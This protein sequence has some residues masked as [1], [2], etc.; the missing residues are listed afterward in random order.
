[1][2]ISGEVEVNGTVVA[3]WGLGTLPW[4]EWIMGICFQLFNASALLHA[5]Y[6]VN[7]GCSDTTSGGIA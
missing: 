6:I 4:D 5:R 1:M 2:L 7:T 3:T